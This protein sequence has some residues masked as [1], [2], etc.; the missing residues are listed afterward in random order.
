MVKIF[1][2]HLQ[3]HS[4]S[5]QLLIPIAL[6]CQEDIWAIFQKADK[7]NSKTLTVKEFQEVLD[8]ICERYPQVQLYLKSKQLSSL[9]DLLKDPN[10]DSAKKSVEVNLEEFKAA[11]SQVDSQMK[12]LPATAQV[13]H[14]GGFD[15]TLYLKYYS[16]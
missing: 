7:D 15:I 16:N 2:N 8:D 12:N 6:T 13:E 1:C 3:I 10:G 5:A 9:V 11:L 4:V 14:H